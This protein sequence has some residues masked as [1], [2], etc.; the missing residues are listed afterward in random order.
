MVHYIVSL[1]AR[2]LLVILACSRSR[3]YCAARK[4][5]NCPYRVRVE[6]GDGELR[7]LGYDQHNYHRGQEQAR[8]AVA[9]A[10]QKVEI[11]RFHGGADQEADGIVAGEMAEREKESTEARLE[12]IPEEGDEPEV[13]SV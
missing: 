7:I 13:S 4:C 3:Y 5:N 2:H 6:V 10:P 1:G 11:R 9:R 12:E 8:A